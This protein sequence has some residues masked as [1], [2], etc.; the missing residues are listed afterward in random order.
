VNFGV[1]DAYKEELLKETFNVSVYPTFF[2]LENNGFNNI[3]A[4]EYDSPNR[5]FSSLKNFVGWQ[6][7]KSGRIFKVGRRISTFQLY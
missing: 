7:P 5:T 2:Y 6:Y 4:Y 3:T 1:I